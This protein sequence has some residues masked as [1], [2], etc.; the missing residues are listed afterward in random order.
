MH[1]LTKADIVI[2]ISRGLMLAAVIT[3]AV[4]YAGSWYLGSEGLDGLYRSLDDHIAA[5]VERAVAPK[6]EAVQ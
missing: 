2:S 3:G 1:Q 4:Y 5:S 6:S